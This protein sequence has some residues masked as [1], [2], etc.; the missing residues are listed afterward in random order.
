MF[1]SVKVFDL[2]IIRDL[3]VSTK[4]DFVVCNVRFRSLRKDLPVWLHP[5][6][7]SLR[8]SIFISPHHLAPVHQAVLIAARLYEG[9]LEAQKKEN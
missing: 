7:A 1:R 3:A 9:E 2:K 5:T 6:A 4:T 8:I